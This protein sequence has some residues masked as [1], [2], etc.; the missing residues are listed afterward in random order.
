MSAPRLE[1][2]KEGRG[3]A[4]GTADALGSQALPRYKPLST[5]HVASAGQ[6]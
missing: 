2:T 3:L 4:S 6:L 1:N 5:S